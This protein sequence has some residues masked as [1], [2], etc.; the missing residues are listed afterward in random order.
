MQFRAISWISSFFNFSFSFSPSI[1]WS[2]HPSDPRTS[3]T[4]GQS[5]VPLDKF[6][7][8][9]TE[10]ICN[11][12]VSGVKY[13][14]I[15][16]RYMFFEQK[17]ALNVMKKKKN[18][19]LSLDSLLVFHGWWVSKFFELQYILASA[20]SLKMSQIMHRLVTWN[21]IIL[22]ILLNFRRIIYMSR[23]MVK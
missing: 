19:H 14:K 21:T 12:L 22:C 9:S 23:L 15:I 13:L 18:L 3:E 5:R 7:A 8:Q 20:S 10:E 11:H 16:L 17:I 6:L 4:I 1:S 2:Y